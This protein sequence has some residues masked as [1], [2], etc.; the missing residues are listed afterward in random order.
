MI[1]GPA[2]AVDSE[3]SPIDAGSTDIRISHFNTVLRYNWSKNFGITYSIAL[4]ILM[5]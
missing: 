2:T 4:G 1:T 5:C 3:E